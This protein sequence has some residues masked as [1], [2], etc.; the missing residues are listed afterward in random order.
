METTLQRISAD[1]EQ[2]SKHLLKELY[3]AVG[4]QK[5]ILERQF[6]LNDAALYR[7]SRAST[8]DVIFKKLLQQADR[9]VDIDDQQQP[10]TKPDNGRFIMKDSVM[11]WNATA[12][13]AGKA[14]DIAIPL[15]NALAPH[16][17]VRSSEPHFYKQ[18]NTDQLLESFLKS[19]AQRTA[20]HLLF[21]LVANKRV[22]F[23]APPGAPFEAMKMTIAAG[24]L[25]GSIFPDWISRCWP[26]VPVSRLD[27]LKSTCVLYTC[28]KNPDRG[29]LP[30]QV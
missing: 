16:P 18:V 17:R 2:P 5:S 13:L 24:C 4:L 30:V 11:Y 6:S 29:V 19:P 15:E 7:C 3:D 14:H 26:F 25:G 10:E 20:I 12:A 27:Q 28:F 23:I 1:P 8:R 9:D 21:A 22:L